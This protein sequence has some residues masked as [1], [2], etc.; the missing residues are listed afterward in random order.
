M[1]SEVSDAASADVI[2]SIAELMSAMQRSR[3]LHQ[4]GAPAIGVLIQIAKHGA[5]RPTALA[6][7]LNIDLST[8][9]R[10]LAKLE[11]DGLV[12][13][14]EDPEDRR[15]HVVHLT[16]AG[17]THAKDALVQRILGFQTLISSWPEGDRAEFARLLDRFVT[18]FEVQLAE[19]NNNA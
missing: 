6:A 4:A 8:V 18:D 11:T 10:Q 19:R 2:V 13:R 9:S 7:A 14:A 17:I 15:A 16:D 5:L 12:I 1:R 3:M